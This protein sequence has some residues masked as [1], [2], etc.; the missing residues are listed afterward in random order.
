MKLGILAT[1]SFLFTSCQLAMDWNFEISAVNN[2]NDTIILLYAYDTNSITC[3][4][5]LY[6]DTVLLNNL[7][8]DFLRQLEPQGNSLIYSSGCSYDRWFEDNSDKISIFVFSKDTVNQYSWNEIRDHY[9]VLVRYDLGYE[10]IQK[11][12]YTIPYPPTHEMAGM[13]MYPAISAW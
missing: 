6:P 7:P 5:N 2:T 9:N 11:L 12:D 1:I 8:V 3:D 4:K 13:Q 10:D